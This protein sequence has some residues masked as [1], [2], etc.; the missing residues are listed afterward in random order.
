MNKK[1]TILIILCLLSGFN[2]FNVSAS[3][4]LLYSTYFGSYN[5]DSSFGI[6][7]DFAGNVY[8]T[9]YTDC[10]G[11]FPTTPGA[12]DQIWNNGID[13]FVCKINPTLS[14]ASSLIYSTYLGGSNTDRAYAIAVDSAGNAYI[15]GQTLSSN[16]PT[17][18]NAYD[19]TYNSNNLFVTKL[20]ASGSALL[21]STFFG[22][23]DCGYSIAVDNTGNAYIT[24]FVQDTTFPITGGVFDPW[25]SG[26][27]DGFVSK[28]NPAFSGSSSL[29]YSTYLGGSGSDQ[30]Y[31]IAVDTAGNAYITGQTLSSNFPTTAGAF[32]IT[33]SGNPDLFITKLNSSGSALL[34]STFFGSYDCGYGI[35][36]DNVENTYIT[37][38][39]HYTGYFPTTGGAFDQTF[40]GGTYDGFVC[41]LNT[42]G[43]GTA[44]L[45]YSTYIGGNADDQGYAITIDSTGKT[46]I[47]GYTYSS[48]FPTTNGAYDT[49]GSGSD[50]FMSQLNVAG[51]ALIYSTY[52]GGGNADEGRSVAVDS[53]G[54]VYVTGNTNSSDFSTTGN[55]YDGSWNWSADIFITQMSL[56]VNQPPNPV[57]LLQPLNNSST[58]N[59]QPTFTWSDATDPDGGP[60]EYQVQVDN[61]SNFLSPEYQNA[62]GS[63]T[64]ATPGSELGTGLY[65]W[66]VISRDTSFSANTSAVWTVWILNRPPNPVTLLEPL[67]NSS[68]INH[69]PSFMWSI[70]IDP[71][72]DT[73]EYRVQV[74]NSST[75]FSPEYQSSFGTTTSATST[76]E[77]ISGLYYWRV[78]SRDNSLATNTSSIWKLVIILTV[79]GNVIYS[80]IDKDGFVNQGDTLTIQFD[81]RM[82]VNSATTADFYLPVIGDSL[83]SSATVSIN[84]ANDTQVVIILGVSPTLTLP[85]IFSGITTAGFPSGID[86]SATMTPNAIEDIYGIDARDGGL[87]GVDDSGRDILFTLSASTTFVSAYSAATVQ[88]SQDTV[89]VYYTEHKLVIPSNS[90]TT[91][92]TIS[93]GPPG[94]NHGELSAVSLS[95]ANVTFS[96]ETPATL[97]LEYK[98]ADIK[99]DLGYMENALRIHQWKDST[100]GWVLIPQTYSQQ[101]VDPITKTVSIKIDKFNMVATNTSVVYANIALPSVG[102]TTTTVAPAPSGFS[103]QG[104]DG[105]PLRNV[106]P[107]FASG[108]ELPQNRLLFSPTTSVTLSVTTAGIYTKHKL[109]LTDYTTAY[110]GVTVILCQPTLP[111]KH[112]WQNYAV[113]KIVT[114]GEITTQAV[115]TMEYKDYDDVNNQFKNDIIGGE[116]WQMRVYRWRDDL[117]SWETVPG[118]QSVNLTENTVTATLD[119]LSLSQ[120]YAVGVDSAMTTAVDYPWHK[121]D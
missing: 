109:T 4:Q 25:Y 52:L 77:L 2:V 108:A 99:R 93:F 89:N 117:W 83:G 28:I 73:V 105:A 39:S 74:D 121:Y 26:S 66:R 103:F 42:L 60:V 37:G 5:D 3:A 119:S 86:I 55:A 71:D 112:D 87:P 41:K 113:L 68:T 7:V 18:S 34:Y 44:S 48:N 115:L 38:Y 12:F 78:I 47:T 54:N 69:T 67:D 70:A 95:P 51:S 114:L 106:N 46:Y 100:T 49:T 6:A 76:T 56:F 64:E 65:Y 75:F 96:T 94:D 72:G 8:I 63:S 111:E 15:T 116:E 20:N 1:F 23:S 17:T 53:T 24:G 22:S 31:A 29:V 84:T 50:V 58:S 85:G 11:G 92:A 82:R 81:R 98:D 118:M 36:V 9:G 120:I 62:F 102:A 19:S 33:F 21:Y 27:G 88:V 40:S 35:A 57:T 61:N 14:G 91:S 110:S 13:S 59:H 80:D 32:D 45:I 107:P 79:T 97:V 101:S 104:C 30:A 10:T 16:F 90:L 43:S